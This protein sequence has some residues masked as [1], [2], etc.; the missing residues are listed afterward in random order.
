MEIG[1]GNISTESELKHSTDRV[2]NLSMYN[3]Y[4]GSIEQ[5]CLYFIVSSTVYCIMHNLYSF[6]ICSL[7]I[8]FN[9]FYFENT[10][11]YYKK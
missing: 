3:N 4:C 7:C 6:E 9:I 5:L 1:T 2:L 11:V 8:I 10:H